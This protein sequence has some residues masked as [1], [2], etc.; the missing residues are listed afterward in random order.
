MKKKKM[1]CLFLVLLMLASAASVVQPVAAAEVGAPIDFTDI[2]DTYWAKDEIDYMSSHGYLIGKKDGSFGPNDPIMRKTVAL[3][4]NRIEGSP[5]PKYL[6][7]FDDIGMDI[8]YD[9]I[10]WTN[11]AGIV[12]GYS[13][14]TFRPDNTITRQHFAIMMYRYAL[15]KGYLLEGDSSKTLA[16]FSDSSSISNASKDAALWAYQ[17]GIIN[18]RANG[19]FDPNGST[20]R[21]QLAV[22]MARFLQKVDGMV[23]HEHTF[24]TEV[25]EPTCT[26]D[27]YTIFT[28][29]CGYT[30]KGDYV[31]PPTGFHLWNNWVTIKEATDDEEGLEWRDCIRCGFEQERSIC[32]TNQ[33]T[34]GI[35]YKAVEEYGN[36]YAAEHFGWYYLE[37]APGYR[38]ASNFEVDYVLEHGGIDFL[39]MRLSQKLD[40]LYDGYLEQS[41]SA[42][43]CCHVWEDNG[44]IWIQVNYG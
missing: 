6:C 24:S 25:I 30:Y 39:K 35:D 10:K 7:M 29:S 9:A 32:R 42:G 34:T 2:P 33:N 38:P 19:T 26:E 22:I 1:M 36:N 41:N 43:I 15:Y 40:L 16:D 17:N 44:I 14:R 12:T 18:G 23:P 3:L 20:T 37:T 11:E 8:Y 28:C 5:A 27:G 31:D 4:L 21:A 13:D